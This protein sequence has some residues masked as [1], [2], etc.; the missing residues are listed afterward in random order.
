MTSLLKRV[1]SSRRLWMLVGIVAAV[2][3]LALLWMVWDRAQLL[4]TGTEVLLQT[5]PVDPRSL[6]QGDYVILSYEISRPTVPAVDGAK[7]AP[8]GPVY[9]TLA[10]GPQDVWQAVA[11]TPGRPTGTVAGQVV[12]KGTVVD[13]WQSGETASVNIRYG[14]EAYFVPEG[15]GRKLEEMVRDKSLK[16]LAAV[17]PDGKAAIKGLAVD[18]TVAFVEPLL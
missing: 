11:Y 8:G 9:V 3:T 4:R 5:Q 6:F 2:Q 12:L 15:E 18:G 16:V 17:G 14:L 7:L 1:T 13:V 10:K